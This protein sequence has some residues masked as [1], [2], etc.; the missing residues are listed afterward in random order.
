MT[1]NKFVKV[2]TERRVSEYL[3]SSSNREQTSIEKA[4]IAE[5]PI[6]T[7]PYLS[8]GEVRELLEE[9]GQGKLFWFKIL[10]ITACR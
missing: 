4:G 10:L 9:G 8:Y 2:A 1:F 7:T 3:R 5:E 6:F